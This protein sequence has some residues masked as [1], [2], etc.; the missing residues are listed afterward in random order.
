[1]I[2]EIVLSHPAYGEHGLLT[3]VVPADADSWRHARNVET[4][5]ESEF[6]HLIAGKRGNRD[7]DVLDG[8]LAP[9]GCDDDF[10]KL[11]RFLAGGL[12]PSLFAIGRQRGGRGLRAV[13]REGRRLSTSMPPAKRR[14]LS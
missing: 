12:G 7:P 8:L 11:A 3:A 9:L 2:I 13:V 5:L 10:R 6:T 4:V 14:L 1:M